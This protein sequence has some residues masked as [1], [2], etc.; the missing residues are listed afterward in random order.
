M[1]F[2]WYLIAKSK[3]PAWQRF[4]WGSCGGAITGPQNFIKDSL[5]TLKAVIATPGVKIPWFFP[6][7]IVL[8]CVTSFVGLLLFTAAM[9]RYNATYCAA[10]Y[11]GSYVMSAS[12][13]SIMHYD[14]FA[15]LPGAWNDAMYPFGLFVLMMGVYLLEVT[16]VEEESS[17]DVEEE[18]DYIFDGITTIITH[19]SPEEAIEKALRDC[20]E[21]FA[22]VQ[23]ETKPEHEEEG[24]AAR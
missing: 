3:A 17:E 20:K 18:V 15:S 19:T 6:L 14:T 7:L 2:L 23:L 9:K 13:N 24:Q 12:I 1:L 4:A 5:T 21:A 10:A 16:G 22:F 8:A 11:V